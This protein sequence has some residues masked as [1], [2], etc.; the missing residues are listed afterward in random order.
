MSEQKDV[1]YDVLAD[2]GNDLLIIRIAI[3]DL[4]EQDKNAH[5]VPPAK[6]KRLA[7]NIKKRGAL[8]SVPYTAYIDGRVE[9]ISGHHRVRAARAA[10]FTHVVVLCDFSGLTRSAAAAKQLAHNHLVG[11]DD[12]RM[13]REVI[14]LIEEADDLLETGMDEEMLPSYQDEE[15]PI[16]QPHLEFGWKTLTFA[17]LPEHLEAF[18]ELL[19][20]IE[21]RQD[22]LGAVPE[23]VYDNFLK[24]ASRFSRFRGVSNIGSVVYLLT[25]MAQDYLEENQ[26]LEPDQA[27]EMPVE[28]L[29]PA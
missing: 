29:I 23:P 19:H 13:V 5:V 9:I 25:K 14:A 15:V 21:G 3:A 20:T 10:A 4:R 12:D 16:P 1:P 18:E 27:L 28:P 26:L 8:E 17:A 22:M 24:Q 7:E 2:L 6:L 11:F